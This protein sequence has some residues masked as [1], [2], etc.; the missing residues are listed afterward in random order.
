MGISV[1]GGMK[2]TD[3]SHSGFNSKLLSP[4]FF[5]YQYQYFDNTD[6]NFD[7]DFGL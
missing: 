5:D 6:V 7:I 4:K 3:E 1:P 2:V